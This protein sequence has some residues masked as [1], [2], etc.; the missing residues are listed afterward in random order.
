[1]QYKKEW[2]KW[3]RLIGDACREGKRVESI[4]DHI[5]K[6]LKEYETTQDYEMWCSSLFNLMIIYDLSN[7][8]I[9]VFDENDKLLEKDITAV[10]PF[11]QA[12]I[13]TGINIDCLNKLLSIIMAQY[14][15]SIKYKNL[16]ERLVAYSKKD[17]DFNV[18]EDGTIRGKN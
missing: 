5:I 9:P 3:I 18:Q 8:S 15:I 2:M 14:N 12:I 10:P 6:H 16:Y 4:K 17:V 1:M 13:E 11:I 7:L